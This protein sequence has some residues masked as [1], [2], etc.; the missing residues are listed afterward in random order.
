MSVTISMP[1]LGETVTE[2]T[3]LAWVKEI[4]EYVAEDEILVEISTDKVDTEIPSPAQGVLVEILVAAG[5]TVD[6]GTPIAV[7]SDEAE[8]EPVLP[9]G[10]TAEERS[11][12]AE[13]T[14]EPA[15][16]RA[17]KTEADNRER[18]GVISPVVRRLA[19]EHGI[20][21][22]MV[23]GTGDGGRITRRDVEAFADA[24]PT[25]LS[26]QR[27]TSR[28][29]KAGSR[30]RPLLRPLQVTFARSGICDG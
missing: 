6:V 2:G 5:T 15:S 19:D 18:R 22:A 27:K 30:K 29:P 10:R 13:G 21:L 4:G 28:Q 25:A 14:S 17:A 1:Q 11:D 16:Q 20:D 3:I 8:G 26:P 12:D 7:L 9:S 23:A 24:Q